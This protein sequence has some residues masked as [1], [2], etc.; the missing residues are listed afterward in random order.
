MNLMKIARKIV[1]NWV[2]LKQACISANLGI[3]DIIVLFKLSQQLSSFQY[4]RIVLEVK[5]LEHH[6]KHSRRIEN[7]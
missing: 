6:M 3:Y 2:N 5:K 7:H 1:Q 4:K